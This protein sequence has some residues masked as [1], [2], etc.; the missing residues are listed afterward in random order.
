MK[1]KA[2]AL[3]WLGSRKFRDP[4]L[5]GEPEIRVITDPK[6]LAE[7]ED[8]RVAIYIR[9]RERFFAEQEAKAAGAAS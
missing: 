5:Q 3:D 4:R 8:R 2:A 7:M 1:T 9:I 6:V